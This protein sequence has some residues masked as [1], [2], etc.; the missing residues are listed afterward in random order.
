VGFFPIYTPIT[1]QWLTWLPWPDPLASELSPIVPLHDHLWL[2]LSAC[3]RTLAALA[4][5]PA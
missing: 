3:D 2:T 4:Y 1:R 5:F